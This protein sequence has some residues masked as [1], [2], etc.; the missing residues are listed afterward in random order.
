VTRSTLPSHAVRLAALLVLVAGCSHGSTNL[1]GH[2]RGVRSEGVRA[3]V[4]EATNAYAA[5]MRVDVKG[6]VI[7][8][9]TAK[10]T[11]TDRYTVVSEEKTKTVIATEQDGPNDPQTFA[12]TDATTMKWFVTPGAAVVFT[13]E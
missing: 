2:W 5:H 8:V 1:A 10:D 7:T 4:L 3:D 9:T 12:F 11:R 6:D 13:K